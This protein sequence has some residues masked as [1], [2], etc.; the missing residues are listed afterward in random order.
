MKQTF[1]QEDIILDVYGESNHVD[2]LMLKDIRKVDCDK[3]SFYQQVKDVKSL[4]DDFSIQPPQR[5]IDAILD[6]SQNSMLSM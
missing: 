3:H 4:I 6:R 5:L 2:H 1:T